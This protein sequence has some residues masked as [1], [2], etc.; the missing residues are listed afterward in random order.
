MGSISS[1]DSTKSLERELD[2]LMREPFDAAI[3]RERSAFDLAAG[4][5]VDRIVL[6]GAGGMGRRTLAGLRRVGISPLAFADNNPGSQ[7][8]EIEGIPVLSPIEATNRFANSAVFVITVW[9]TFAKD[10]MQDRIKQ[11]R[12]LGCKR[13]V[14]AGLLFW[15]YPEEFLPFFPMDLPHKVLPHSSEIRG[16]LEV[17]EEPIS[18]QEFIGQLR[19]RLMMDFDSM[20]NPRGADAYFQTG[21]FES[22]QEEVFVDC[23]AFDGD[24]IADFLRI[25][26]S[27]FREIVA[28]EPDQ[29]NLKNLQERLGRMER[30]LR[31]R[32][33]V[34]PYA[35]G[36][37][38]GVVVF[39]SAGSDQSRIGEGTESVQLMTL[40]ESLE[41]KC[42]SFIKFDIEGAEL[43]ALLGARRTIERHRPILAVSAYH[44][45]SHLWQV[46]IFLA[47]ACSD[48][49]FY[50]RPHGAEGWDLVCYAVPDER[51]SR[52]PS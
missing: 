23:G 1:T 26:G 3:A 30:E 51:A 14:P 33:T 19:F 40:D 47:K 50:L 46:P 31:E 27:S 35:L 28:F 36:A 45:Q 32:I 34:F 8:R 42:P 6:F 4:H 20:G 9:S 52:R 49:K 7:G 21:L 16:A 12:D 41:Q 11:L 44:Q 2:T 29:V 38:R 5:L 13:V 43:D 17:F 24:T 10:R 39:P 37:Q 25:Q 18:R 22:N 15:K 48:Y